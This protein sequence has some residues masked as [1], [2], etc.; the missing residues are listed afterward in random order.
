MTDNEFHVYA[1]ALIAA[2]DAGE[3]SYEEFDDGY[4]GLLE[5]LNEEENA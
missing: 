1:Q 5:Q 2:F 4:E 3:I